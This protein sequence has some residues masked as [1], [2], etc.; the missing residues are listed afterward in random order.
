VTGSWKTISLVTV[1]ILSAAGGLLFLH[2]GAPHVQIAPETAFTVGGIGITNTMITAYLVTAVLALS[3]WR[4]TRRAQIVPGRLQAG[5]E[6]IVET[7]LGLCESVAGLRNGRRFFTLVMTIFLFVV[8]ANWMGLLPGFGTIGKYEYGEAAEAEQE[9]EAQASPVQIAQGVVPDEAKNEAPVLVPFLRGATT[10]L[11]AT[12]SLA[13]I[14]VVATQ[15]FGIRTLG[16]GNYLSKFFNLKG[17]PIGAF[18]GIVELIGE[19]SRIISFSF[20]LF[21]NIF[22]GEVLLAVVAFLV[23]LVATLPFL[24]LELFVG[25]LQAFI[26]AMLTLVFLSIATVGHG[27]HH[28]EKAEHGHEPRVAV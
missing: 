16:A 21:G 12:L 7:F 8:V 17:G 4:A 26:F 18:I 23:P 25:V 22:A 3:F 14:S 5:A 28:E 24:G 19:F 11:N 15:V 10:D 13:I 20:R 1:V 2:W 6:L 9:P 27:E